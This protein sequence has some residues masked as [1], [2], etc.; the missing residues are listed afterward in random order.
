[1]EHSKKFNKLKSYYDSG[2]WT[3]NMLYNA[4]RKRWITEEEF[5]E[6]IGEEQE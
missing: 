6:I 3:R 5:Y 1:M 2:L 4:V